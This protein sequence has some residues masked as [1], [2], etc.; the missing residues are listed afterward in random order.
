MI[1]PIDRHLCRRLPEADAD[2]VVHVEAAPA[3][4]A[5][6][7]IEKL[8][9]ALRTAAGAAVEVVP[10]ARARFGVKRHGMSCLHTW[11]KG[12]PAGARCLDPEWPRSAWESALPEWAQQRA[13]HLLCD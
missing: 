11:D 12:T 13:L 5:A 2:R 10:A 1:S 8:Q 6:Q 7:V 4:R 9:E 3:A